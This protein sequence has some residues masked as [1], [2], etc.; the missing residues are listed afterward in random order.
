MLRG[1]AFADG[2]A[3]TIGPALAATE[4]RPP[5]PVA[6]DYFDYA[7]PPRRRSIWPWLLAVL[8]VAAAAIAG[9]Y[10]YRQIQDQLNQN[11]AGRRARR[12]RPARRRAR[13]TTSTPRGSRPMRARRARATSTASRTAASRRATSSTRTR[14]P[15]DRVGKGSFVDICVSTGKAQVLVP[16]VVGKSS[17]DAVAELTRKNLVAD[18]HKIASSQPADTVIAQDPKGGIKVPEKTKVR[19]NVS[20]GPKPI[21]IPDV[22]GSSYESAASQLQ[23]LGFAVARSDVDS[24]AAAAGIVIDQE[25]AGG[26]FVLEGLD[27]D[28]HGVEGARTTTGVPNVENSRRRDREKPARRVRV[29][30]EGAARGHDGSVARRHRDLAGSG[31]G[32]AARSRARR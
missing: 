9:F 16:D 26:S 8:L 27:G 31:R 6:P 20:S 18:V 19:I 25:P 28:A 10:V 22:R 29:Q 15:G 32:H 13:C 5:P 23:A 1:A 30:G 24:N 12:R 21:G 4:T 7:Q 17:N 3:T 2:A 11:A 14:T